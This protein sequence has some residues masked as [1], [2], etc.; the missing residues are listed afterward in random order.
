M[1]SV[2]ALPMAWE[3]ARPTSRRR[4][5]PR[6][7]ERPRAPQKR[8]DPERRRDPGKPTDWWRDSLTETLPDL[9]P[10]S[11]RRFPL[12]TDSPAVA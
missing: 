10:G 12:E 5:R 11:A 8:T 2:R 6:D 3:L 9:L 4:E 1:A 7:L